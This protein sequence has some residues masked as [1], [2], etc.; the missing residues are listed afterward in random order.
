[1]RL[2]GFD[3]GAVMYTSLAVL[4]GW[5]WENWC[6]VPMWCRPRGGRGG[7]GPLGEA[8]TWDPWVDACNERPTNNS[9]RL[10]GFPTPNEHQ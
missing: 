5:L 6:S 7:D 8:Q 2:R 3:G 9:G 10:G 1:M 4:M